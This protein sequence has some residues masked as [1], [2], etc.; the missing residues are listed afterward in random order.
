M[1]YY[2]ISQVEVIMEPKEAVKTKQATHEYMMQRQQEF[3]NRAISENR[4]DE[5]FRRMSG[6]KMI[7]A[8][9]KHKF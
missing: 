9:R 2:E 3:Q 4:Q 7:D 6:Q 8:A 5:E 1:T